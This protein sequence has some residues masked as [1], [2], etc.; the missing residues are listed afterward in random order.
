MN[1]VVNTNLEKL[2]FHKILEEPKQIYKVESNFFENEQ[3]RFIYDVVRNE[4]IN[5]SDKIIPHKKQIWSMIQLVDLN[6]MITKDAFI[7]LFSENTQNISDDWLEKRFKA[8]KS[9]KY[10]RQKMYESI[11]LIKNMEELDYDNVKSIVTK[12]KNNF[13][14]IEFIDNDDDDLGSD[15]DD[16][17][18]HKQHLSTTKMSSGWSN[19]DKL[20]AGGWDRATLN[21]IM[22][23][24]SVGKCTTFLTNIKIR[25]KKTNK[26][27]NIKLGDF[28][29]LI[30]LNNK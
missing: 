9:S 23:E 2:F 28:F 13:A 21:V 16:P 17:E 15:F 27:E 3:I 1:E 11:D 30:K 20:L 7:N 18:N 5:S 6:K 10:S 14:E 8:W 24:T 26:I 22:G 29:N 25:N 19:I 4:Y 12:L